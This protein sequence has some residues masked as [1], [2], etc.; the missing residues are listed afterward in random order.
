MSRGFLLTDT[1]RCAPKE[2]QPADIA[3][4]KVLKLVA[5]I[6]SIFT[7]LLIAHQAPKDQF[8]NK[9]TVCLLQVGLILPDQLIKWFYPVQGLG[10]LFF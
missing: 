6:E 1:V 3:S 5:F 9:V 7:E 2:L 10:I 4:I 8:L